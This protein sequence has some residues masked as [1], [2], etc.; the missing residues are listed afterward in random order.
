MANNYLLESIDSLSLQKERE[1]IMKENDYLDASISFYDLEE[2]PLVNALEDLDTYG[3]LT[4]KKVIII[5]N[6]EFLKYDDFKD[7]VEHFFRYLDSPNPDYL[8][9]IESHKL[10][11]TTK[12]TKTLK[13]KCKYL[14]ISMDP[15]KYIQNAFDGYQLDTGVVS[16]LEEYCLGDITK[17]ENE[18]QK[19]KDYKL[20]EKVIT[21][22]DVEDFVIKK[23]GDPK[24]L[25]FAFVRSLSSR[26]RKEAL[27]K[28]QELL[29][30][31]ME[32]FG[33]L[34]LLASQFRILYQV[35]LLE[36]ER[37]SDKEIAS[38]LG[39]KSDYRIRKTKEL[40]RLYSEN[41]ILE[42]IQRL[43]NIDFQ[44]KTTDADGNH[45]LEMFILSI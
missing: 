30:Y 6:I 4:S 21:K 5:Q 12:I 43:A 28:Y 27:L 32:P 33:I 2:V 41:D 37:K 25:T 3:F 8:L 16:L 10:N 23:L 29:S 39:E 14:E 17:I 7:D 18:T 26:D 24:D 20:D 31:Q 1:R 15:K 40:T 22:K 35:K 42:M 13:S 45:L 44:L 38:I 9:I 36:K 19:L 11:N 34:G